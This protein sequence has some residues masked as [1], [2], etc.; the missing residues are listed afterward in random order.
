[1]P[2]WQG[3]NCVIELRD[4]MVAL[5]RARLAAF[6]RQ[7][8]VRNNVTIR[9]GNAFVSLHRSR[10]TFDR[11][12]VGAAV[13]PVD[14]PR[15]LAMLAVGS[16]MLVP[17]YF[18]ARRGCAREARRWHGREYLC[19]WR[20]LLANNQRDQ[21][22]ASARARQRCASVGLR[23]LQTQCLVAFAVSRCFDTAVSCSHCGDCYAAVHASVIQWPTQ[24]VNE[25]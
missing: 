16:V 8:N 25:S 10:G 23:Q 6:C 5:S 12:D 3:V 19:I 15:L 4:E 2:S 24:E 1:M 21:A 20:S 7:V 14:L 18:S 11:I 17:Q 13:D 9:H 22:S